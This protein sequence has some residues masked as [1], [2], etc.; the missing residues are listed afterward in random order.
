MTRIHLWKKEPGDGASGGWQSLYTRR[1]SPS[2]VQTDFA[3]KEPK[4]VGEEHGNM[5][6]RELQ[7]HRDKDRGQEQA[8]GVD[9]SP[10]VQ[11]NL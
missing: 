10:A 4:G 9:E 7:T 1:P 5:E 8:H 11:P 2:G 3:A 6:W